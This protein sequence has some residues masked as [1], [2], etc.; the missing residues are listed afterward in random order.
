M[1]LRSEFDGEQIYQ[2]MQFLH[3]KKCAAENTVSDQEG[4]EG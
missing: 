2:P 3:A 1:M 4:E